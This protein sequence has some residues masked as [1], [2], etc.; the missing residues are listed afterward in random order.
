[1]TATGSRRSRGHGDDR[2]GRRGPSRP[3]RIGTA[4][5]VLL[6][7]LALALAVPV[8]V[9]PLDLRAQAI[10]G[11]SVFALAWLMNRFQARG[12]TLALMGVSIVVSSRYIHWRLTSTL[13]LEWSLDGV[14]AATLLAAELYTFA[15]L[16][17]GYFQTAWPLARKPVPLPDDPARWPTVDV[18]IP[19]YNEP[20]KVVR[21]TVLAAR[22][23]EWPDAKLRVTILDDGNRG[24][25]RSFA[26]NARVGY[27]GRQDNRH[28]KAGNIN[29]ALQHTD[30][31]FVAIFDCD[32]V[33]TRSFLQVA[34]GWLVRDERMAMVQLPHHFHSPDPFERNLGV[35]RKIPNEGKLF[36][37]LLQPGN[38]LWNASFFCGSCAVLRRS[39]LEEV[40][41]IA[42]ETVTEDAHTALRLH[43]Q[44]YRTAYLGVPQ[45][46][47]LATES[48]AVHVGQRIRW[49][50]GMVQIFRVDNPLLGRGLSLGQRLCYTNA[51]VYFLN[52]LPRL[53]FLTAPLY[54]LFFGAH[55]FNAAPALVVAYAAPHLA[56]ILMTNARTQGRFRHAFWGDVFDTVQAFYILLPTLLALVNPRLGEFNVTAK[57]GLVERPYFDL[58]LAAPLLVLAA[59][60][61]GG[62]AVAGWR[63]PL[64][65][66]HLD[67]LAMNAFWCVLNLIVLGAGIAVALERRQVRTSIRVGAGLPAVLRTDA[68]RTLACRTV[69]L[70]LGGAQL[71][72]PA[73]SAFAHDERVT[74]GVVVNDEELPLSARV[75]SGRPGGL[76]VRFDDLTVEEEGWLV[77]ALYARANAW[78]DWDEALRPDRVAF[79]PLRLLGDAARAVWTTLVRSPR[80]LR[81]QSEEAS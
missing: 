3:S 49:A 45:A 73:D 44:G 40:G 43:R 70:S 13:D 30:G 26:A 75:V 18:F 24:E 32:H 4:R 20:L 21:A 74:V 58:K 37:G 65:P 42:V 71:R 8:I 2:A 12:V 33:P 16:L 47:G 10:L 28:A 68:G 55:I 56:H 7:L 35:F 69:D 67:A 53:V 63:V 23:M 31:D 54:F 34:M 77:R 1:M 5:D 72:V 62:L 66:Q 14:L 60:N 48:A 39:A 61:L 29:N 41:G 6:L 81:R 9:I 25:F 52:A 27:I 64:D 76:R 38:D 59:A 15:T 80:R 46:S 57:G 50:R 19:T 36:Y 22:A 78:E 17:L 51:M 11:L 79:G